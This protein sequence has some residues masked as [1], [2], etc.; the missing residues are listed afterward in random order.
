VLFNSYIFL[1]IFLPVVIAGFYGLGKIAG[2]G[3]A[4]AWLLVSSLFFYGYWHPPY[5]VL[6]VISILAN[7]G[8]SHLIDRTE[9]KTRRVLAAVGIAA[10]LA[11]LAYYKYAL[12]LLETVT[13]LL[14]HPTFDLPD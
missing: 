5:L 14:G 8:W 11:V 13:P 6:L 2:Q 1:L 12:F 10:N 9:G 7:Y 3:T 4:F